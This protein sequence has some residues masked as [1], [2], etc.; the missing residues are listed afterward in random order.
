MT[1]TRF[2][3]IA[4]AVVALA[5]FVLGGPL[6]SPQAFA[7]ANAIDFN[8]AY[9]GVS[10]A[11]RGADPYRVEPLRGC[12]H[13]VTPTRSHDRDWIVVPAPLPGYT[14]FLL[15]PF[16]HV[17]YDV[18][19][20]LWV[21]FG[22]LALLVASLC[23][24]RVTNLPAIAVL[25]VFAPSIGLLNLWYGEPV[26]LAIAFLGV[27]ALAAHERRDAL[28][29]VFAALALL[30]PHVGL[31]ACV[32]A[33]IALPRSRAAL[34]GTLAVLALLS[35]AALG[36]RLNLEYVLQ[37]LPAQARSEIAVN[38]QLSLAHVLNLAGVPTR[39]AVALGSLSYA[40]TTLLGSAIAFRLVERG[41]RAAAISLPVTCAML[42]GPYV[43]TVE[44]AAA[45]PGALLLC[46][47][48]E[49]RA[50][51]AAALGLAILV[52]PWNPG[53]TA[54]V[55]NVP[56]ALTAA[57][58][59]TALALERTGAPLRAAAL[60]TLALGL[61][62]AAIPPGTSAPPPQPARPE[63]IHPDDLSSRAWT[64]F[65]LSSPVWPH[66]DVE[67]VML[68]APQWGAL[69]LTIGAALTLIPVR[70]PSRPPQ[71]IG[72]PASIPAGAR[73]RLS[74]TS[75]DTLASGKEAL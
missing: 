50:R 31:P 5:V 29:G 51:L 35:L 7:R 60:V 22:V 52:I 28:A 55:A 8:A 15:R 34:T 57:F 64:M 37:A 1:V 23:A 19:K 33:F 58:V 53:A 6:R 43:H 26:P 16:A 39:T 3:A 11:E 41:Y 71:P 54:N 65:V 2:A 69:L 46:T 49:G 74:A 20:M 70:F 40:A 32:G 9:C 42:G 63:A 48:L 4:V 13:E 21:A 17:P 14:F 66:E 75:P 67:H 68:K 30:E 59:A 47:I 24:A 12:E 25:L 73:R 56:L 72:E 10:V 62:V 44:I 27:A 38:Y 36:P 45:I 61:Y 18:A